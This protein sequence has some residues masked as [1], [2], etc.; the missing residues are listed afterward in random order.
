MRSW[1][2]NLAA[3]VVV[4]TVLSLP[5][6][7]GSGRAPVSLAVTDSIT[8][9]AMFR[10]Q[11]S[12]T[13]E[14]CR[15]PEDWN[16]DSLT[17]RLAPNEAIPPNGFTPR[18]VVKRVL[19][20]DSAWIAFRGFRNGFQVP[21]SLLVSSKWSETFGTRVTDADGWIRLRLIDRSP[22]RLRPPVKTTRLVGR[23]EDDST[24]CAVFWCWLTIN[25]TK[26]G[27]F[28]D[29]LGHFEIGDVPVGSI[30]LNACA[31][32]HEWKRLEIRVPCGALTL[33][34]RRHPGAD[35]RMQSR[36]R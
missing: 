3:T 23:V 19:S 7:V 31:F 9:R 24:G 2:L 21:D 36:C 33:Q 26:L 32:G 18:F 5:A 11:G 28:T 25:G 4:A 29:T 14:P 16:W 35:T 17:W 8:V 6:A 15:L 10:W 34:L 30:S 27:A 1:S 12:D 22:E 13:M 20:R